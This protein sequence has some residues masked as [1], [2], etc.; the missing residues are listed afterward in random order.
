MTEPVKI[1]TS[2]LREFQKALR[3]ADAG[4]PKRVRL[5][6]NEAAT[7]I[8]DYAQTHITVVS[9]RARASIKARSSQ[10]VAAI[11]TGG[12]RAPY[13]PWWDFGGEGR[14]KG[15]PSKRPF[16]KEGRL[17]YRGLRIHQDDVT[18]IMVRGLVELGR[19]AGVEVSADG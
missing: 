4:L 18:Q 9:G 7:L 19:E 5:I 8:V 1:E 14:I 13:E 11:A 2:G 15:R 16:I 6:L 17:V 12:T 10:R 3:A